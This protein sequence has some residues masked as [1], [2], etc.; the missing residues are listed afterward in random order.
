MS[1]SSVI[2]IISSKVK[3][4][5]WGGGIYLHPVC[6]KV[7]EDIIFKSVFLVQGDLHFLQTGEGNLT[8]SLKIPK[9]QIEDP[10]EI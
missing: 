3:L 5:R 10:A 4:V 8:K 2:Y 9:V 7:Q 1:G 6:T